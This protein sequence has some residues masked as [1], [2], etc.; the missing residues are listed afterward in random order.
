MYVVM[1]ATL[2]PFKNNYISHLYL[3]I[4]NIICYLLYLITMLLNHITGTQLRLPAET[5]FQFL[6]C[7]SYK[8]PVWNSNRNPKYFLKWRNWTETV[9]PK[10]SSKK[11]KIKRQL[12]MFINIK[13]LKEKILTCRHSAFTVTWKNCLKKR[14]M[15][16]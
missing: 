8:I 9:I 11:K 16:S 3:I 7:F 15:N 5:V 6:K 14:K 1:V 2:Q 13:K 12:V 4:F 10:K